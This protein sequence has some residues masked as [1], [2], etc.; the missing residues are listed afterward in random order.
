MVNNRNKRK[1]MW[2]DREFVDL[3]ERIKA[4]RLLEGNPIK[5]IPQL[6]KEI[7]ECPSFE[8]VLEEVT[9]EKTIKINIRFDKRKIW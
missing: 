2:A 8:K 7:I 4:K 1:Q 3:L 5:N 9:K 6:T